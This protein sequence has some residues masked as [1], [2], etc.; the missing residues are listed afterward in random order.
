M[1]SP[2]KKRRCIDCGELLK[3]AG[4]GCCDEMRADRLRFQAYGKSL[5]DFTKRLYYPREHRPPI[6]PRLVEFGPPDTH[7][8]RGREVGKPRAQPRYGGPSVGAT[9][10]ECEART[11]PSRAYST[12]SDTPV[13]NGTKERFWSHTRSPK[14]QKFKA[15]KPVRNWLEKAM[16]AIA[17]HDDDLF[18]HLMMLWHDPAVRKPNGN[19]TH[20]YVRQ[21]L[22]WRA[23]DYWR[24]EKA[25]RY[26]NEARNFG[27]DAP[28]EP[29]PGD[30]RVVAQMLANADLDQVAADEVERIA[31][32]ATEEQRQMM[33]GILAGQTQDDIAAELRVSTRT[34]QRKLR[35]LALERNRTIEN[36]QRGAAANGRTAGAPGSAH[37][38]A[39]NHRAGTAATPQTCACGGQ[40]R[41]VCAA[42]H[43][44]NADL[45]V[46][47]TR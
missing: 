25:Y 30:M 5:N 42:I 16:R 14:S 18:Q 26:H 8:S 9:P 44:P 11:V 40:R 43:R 23:D 22:R 20:S 27:L 28:D 15:S 6:D 24:K 37:S 17:R 32:G 13:K 41:A 19:A 45:G 4:K 36:P 10:A 46:K 7:D 31:A 35:S 2:A 33:N 38:G 39:R 29:E 21:W 1:G 34:V 47:V 3:P 12:L